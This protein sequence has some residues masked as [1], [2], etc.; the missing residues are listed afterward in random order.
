M[1]FFTERNLQFRQSV[2]NQFFRHLFYEFSPSARC[3][4]IYGPDGV[5]KTTL[6]LQMAELHTDIPSDLSLILSAGDL[7][8]REESLFEIAELFY[9]NGGRFLLVDDIHFYSDYPSQIGK[10]ISELADLTLILTSSTPLHIDKELESHIISNHLPPLSF[11]EY[12]SFRESIRIDPKKLGEIISFQL[13]FSE[14]ISGLFQP[15]PPHIRVR[16]MENSASNG[17]WNSLFRPWKASTF[18]QLAKSN[19]CWR[20]SSDRDNLN[21]TFQTLPDTSM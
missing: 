5:G 1:D 15:I 12:L 18:A 4:I 10:I 21:Q 17:F 6:L 8:L 19:S 11:R 20:S 2:P 13:E 16:D 9:L 3:T 14:G 7:W